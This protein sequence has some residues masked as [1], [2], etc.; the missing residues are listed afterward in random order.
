M[1]LDMEAPR[2]MTTGRCMCEPVWTAQSL[3]YDTHAAAMRRSWARKH[4]LHSVCVVNLRRW[5]E[6]LAHESV[7]EQGHGQK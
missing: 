1:R 6:S 4:G 2:V 3:G 7:L 5:V